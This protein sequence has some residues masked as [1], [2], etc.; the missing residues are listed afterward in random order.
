MAI[1][2][3]FREVSDFFQ[4][5]KADYA[6]IGALALYAYGY[7]RATRDI[8]F[9]TRIEFQKKVL[10]F[11]ES[12]GFETTH[13][14]SAFS[15]HI[16]PIG[17]LRFDVMYLEKDTADIIFGNTRKAVLFD[18]V[19]IP[20]I[21]PEHLIAMKLFSAKHDETRRLKDLAD[22]QE[23]ITHTKMKKNAVQDY[24]KH[25]GL[26]PYYKEIREKDDD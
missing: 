6:V 17:T 1:K 8:D 21:S 24:F 25:Y 3:V 19:E 2:E 12:L 26:E 18:N 15:N 7:V 13:C 4:R 5:E 22:I 9:V 20:V 11:L 10:L 16:H 14:S 23:I